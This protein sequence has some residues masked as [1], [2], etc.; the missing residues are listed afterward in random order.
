MSL[1]PSPEK[2][3]SAS[4][5][6]RRGITR[7]QAL[8]AALATGVG[9]GAVRLLGGSM[10]SLATPRAGSG[11]DWVSPLG[12]ESARVMQLLRRTSFGYTP[13]QLES[14]LSDGFNRTVDRLIDTNPVEPPVLAGAS[15][16]GGRFPVAQLQQWWLDHILSTPTACAERMTLF[17]H[18]H[19]T[20]DYRKV[21][22]DTFMYWQNLTWRRMS[23]TNLR[24]M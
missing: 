8:A 6:V 10:Q 3:P 18:G 7:R 16:P 4:V 15:T 14:A 23:M 13:V 5:Q 19:F 1:A 22:D 2:V 21:A 24:S 20:S 11:T 17:W 9:V 12:S